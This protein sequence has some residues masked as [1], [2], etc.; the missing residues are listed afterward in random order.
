MARKG[1]FSVANFGNPF[2]LYI[3]SLQAV[4][5]DPPW[6]N[7][8]VKRRKNKTD[9]Y[10]MLD[11]QDIFDKLPII[12][13]ILDTDGLLIIWCTNS[14]KHNDSIEKWLDKWNL[15][16]KATW[17][18]LKVTTYGEPVT[19]WN[20]PHKRPYEPIIIATRQ[21]EQFFFFFCN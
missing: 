11:N 5:M 19:R 9:G 7:K 14:V 10:Q 1:H 12:S 13:D 20:H 21:S 15:I 16:R 8:Y 3:F 6:L 18:W 2:L 4:L 17:Y